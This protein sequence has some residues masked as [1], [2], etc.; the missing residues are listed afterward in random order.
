VRIMGRGMYGGK[1]NWVTSTVDTNELVPNSSLPFHAFPK[2]VVPE[3][4][5]R[6]SDSNSIVRLNV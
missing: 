4:T 1:V 6:S 3:L 2:D 5:V